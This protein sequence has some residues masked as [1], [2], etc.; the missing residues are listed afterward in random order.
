MQ[1]VVVADRA[2]IW[3]ALSIGDHAKLLVSVVHNPPASPNRQIADRLVERRIPVAAAGYWRAYV[4]AFLTREEVRVASNDWVR[5][6]KC[7]ELFIDHLSGGRRHQRE[8]LR[9]R[10]AQWRV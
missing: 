1:R 4:I 6:Q 3:A 8:P 9:W 5:I 10:R 2:L 7:R